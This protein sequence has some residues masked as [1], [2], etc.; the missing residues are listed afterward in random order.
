MISALTFRATSAA[1]PLTFYSGSSN[2]L[3]AKIAGAAQGEH[4]EFARMLVGPGYFSTMNVRLFAGRE[5]QTT[6]ASG[7]PMV[8]IINDEF[9]RRYFRGKSPVGQRVSFAETNFESFA[10]VFADRMEFIIFYYTPLHYRVLRREN[11][12]HVC[13]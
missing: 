9:S 7:A 5:F 6:D 12:V 10:D 4:V 1:V 8:A 2:G 13:L 11:V 3:T